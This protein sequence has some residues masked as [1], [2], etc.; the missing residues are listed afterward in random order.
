MRQPAATR[1]KDETGSAGTYR[2]MASAIIKAPNASKGARITCD[3]RK[4]RCNTNNADGAVA[5]LRLLIQIKKGPAKANAITLN[6]KYHCA[7]QWAAMAPN[8]VNAPAVAPKE[9]RRAMILSI[10]EPP[11]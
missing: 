6:Q 5:R 7:R 8:N 3:R 1:C 10:G 2:A 11:I 9:A 4:K